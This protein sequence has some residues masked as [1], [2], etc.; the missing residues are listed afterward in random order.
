M[1]DYFGWMGGDRS[2]GD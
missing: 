1:E 2:F